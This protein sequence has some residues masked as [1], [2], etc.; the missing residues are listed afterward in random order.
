[1]KF[2][3]KLFKLSL[4][5]DGV[6][7][8]MMP[9][10][11]EAMDK[12]EDRF[13]EIIRNEIDLVSGSPHEWRDILKGHID[14]LREEIE[15][16]IILYYVGPDYDADLNSGLWMRAMVIAYG[17]APPIFAGPKGRIVW[18]DELLARKASVSNYHEIQD[19]WYHEGRE[20]IQ[21]AITLM[22]TEFERIIIGSLSDMPASV[23]ADNIKIL[24]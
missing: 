9:Y 6:K 7:R 12:A 4:D 18:D 11:R 5:A 1:M 15:N 10:I 24:K 3:L 14:H 22:R 23:F 21:N 19:S 8:S 2:E 13:I 16:D 20:Y 17:N